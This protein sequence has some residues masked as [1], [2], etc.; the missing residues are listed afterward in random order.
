MYNVLAG[1][2]SLRLTQ[3]K[4]CAYRSPVRKP[5]PAGSLKSRGQPLPEPF[6]WIIKSLRPG[7]SVPEVSE[8]PLGISFPGKGMHF[9]AGTTFFFKENIL[10]SFFPLFL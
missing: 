8:G 1:H 4:I 6:L 10:F 3:D 9:G 2:L 7:Q 5:C